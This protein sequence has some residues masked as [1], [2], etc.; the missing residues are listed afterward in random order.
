MTNHKICFLRDNTIIELISQFGVLDTKQ[1][2]YLVAYHQLSGYKII[3][4]RMTKLR[5]QNRVKVIKM[6]KEF[7]YV[8]YTEKKPKQLEHKLATIWGYIYIKFNLLKQYEQIVDFNLKDDYGILKP[9]GFITIK[10]NFTNEFRHV[11]IEADLSNNPFDKVI[12]YNKLFSEN[13]FITKDW[14]KQIK[15]S[16]TK[17]FPSI[18]ILTH[19]VKLVKNKIIV[20]NINNLE[21]KVINLN[22]IY[23]S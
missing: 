2:Y 8:Y 1:I 20:D 15:D 10:N 23:P 7:P 11:F 16:P 21:F 9:D 5:K 14:Y 12:K 6:P 4:R 19:R 3:Q 18:L 17:R 22:E 13:R